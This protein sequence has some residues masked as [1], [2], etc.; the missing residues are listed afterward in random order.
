MT[1][2]RVIPLRSAPG[3]AGWMALPERD[4]AVLLWLVGG[5]VITAELAALLA[6]GHRRIAQRRLARLVEYRLLSDSWAANSQR[7]RG[8]YAYALTKASRAG[9]ERLIW[10]D[11]RPELR[12]GV[13]VTAP[14]I[15]QLATHDLFAAFL[16]AGEPGSDQGLAAWVPERACLRLFEGWLRPD[17]V[18]VVRAGERMIVLFVERDLGTERGAVVPEKVHRY[19]SAFSRSAEPPIHL[20]IVVD[21]ARRAASLGRLI[22]RT[23]RRQGPI[24]IWLGPWDGLARDPLRATWTSPAGERVRTLDLVPH[25]TGDPWPPLVPGCLAQPDG[26]EGLDERVFEAIPA[27]VPFAR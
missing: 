7:P 19:R 22:S 24:Q 13:Q 21:S 4:R 15:H 3:L 18:A 14:V 6:Y 5:E 23:D 2:T 9:L 12:S 20:G 26:L 16:R 1:T 8:R 11:G 10:P 17:A 27:L 25:W